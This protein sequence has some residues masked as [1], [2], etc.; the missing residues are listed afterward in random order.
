MTTNT[1]TARAELIRSEA[2]LLQPPQCAADR[3]TATE[4]AGM[5]IQASNGAVKV[6]VARTTR[7]VELAL[8]LRHRVFVGEM[9]A[10]LGLP[11]DATLERDLFDPY[12]EHLLA[13]ET[14]SG[15]V[16]GT[17]RLLLPEKAS[18]L[19]CL[20]CDGEF[21]LTRLNSIRD[22]TVE[23]GRVCVSSDHRDGVTIRLLWSALLNFVE[24]TG[25]RYAI[26]AAS[27]SLEDGGDLATRIYRHLSQTSMAEEPWRAW[28]RRRLPMLEDD[29]GST[30]LLQMPPLIKGYLRMGARLLGEPY[31]DPEFACADF[32]VLVDMW[33]MDRRLLDRVKG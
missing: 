25:Q 12:C 3:I 20:Y 33:A 10:S 2:A 11:G 18:E 4:L 19:G 9:G 5:E 29:F 23:V 31:Y 27:V 17:C 22:Q 24:T 13:V 14:A 30:R 8:A 26:G 15:K 21:W 32:P 1:L 16:I 28:P 7:Q 6:F